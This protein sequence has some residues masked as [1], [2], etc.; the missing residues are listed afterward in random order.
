M[1]LTVL[2]WNDV[3]PEKLFLFICFYDIIFKNTSTANACYW[4]V[5]NI[6]PP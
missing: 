4:N 1:P 5:A 2:V 6:A 3:L